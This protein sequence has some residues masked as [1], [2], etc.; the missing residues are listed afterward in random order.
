M[1]K[2]KKEKCY[3]KFVTFFLENLFENVG[4]HSRL[5]CVSRFEH[6]PACDSFET[7]FVDGT[8]LS[9]PKL[10]K[11][12]SEWNPFAGLVVSFEMSFSPTL[13]TGLLSIHTVCC[14]AG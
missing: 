8:V 11:D 9:I 2:E 1:K 3:L 5:F 4:E 10:G 7:G 12:L 14:A 6:C 13:A